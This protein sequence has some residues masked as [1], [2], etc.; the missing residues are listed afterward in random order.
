MASNGFT[1]F[2]IDFYDLCRSVW[3][4]ND[5]YRLSRFTWMYMDLHGISRIQDD[6]YGFL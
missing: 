1:S 3:M 5:L 6:L 2:Y 4:F